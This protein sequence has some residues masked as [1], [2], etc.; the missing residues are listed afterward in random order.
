MSEIARSAHAK[1][2]ER[3]EALVGRG[4]DDGERS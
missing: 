3:V 1:P 2:A 4:Q